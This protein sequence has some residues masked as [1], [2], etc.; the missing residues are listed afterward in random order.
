[1]SSFGCQAVNQ[2]FYD[3]ANEMG[4]QVYDSGPVGSLF[5]PV[6]QAETAVKDFITAHP[7]GEVYVLGY[8]SGGND[9]IALVNFLQEGGIAVSGLVTFDPHPPFRLGYAGYKVNNVDAVNFYQRGA[10]EI[11]PNTFHGSVVQG[12]ANVDMTGQAV[13]NNIVVR[14]QKLYGNAINYALQH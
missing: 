10:T 14:A 11:G 12:A 4:A 3:L 9:A 13:H 7:D 6:G 5:D 2:P 8:S 1:M